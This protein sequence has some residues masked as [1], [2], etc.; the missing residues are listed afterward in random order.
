MY[1]WEGDPDRGSKGMKPEYLKARGLYDVMTDDGVVHEDG[2]SGFQW[3]WALNA[4]RRCVELGPVA[5]PRNHGHRG[6][7]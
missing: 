2:L 3:G 6:K 4:A 1:D 5:E 7:R